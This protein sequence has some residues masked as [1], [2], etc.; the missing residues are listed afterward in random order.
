[1]GGPGSG[2]GSRRRNLAREREA[3]RLREQGLTLAD[4]LDGVCQHCGRVGISGALL[5]APVPWRAPHRAP[6]CGA[7]SA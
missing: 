7:S 4:A 5:L 1:M 3:V 2:R 6:G